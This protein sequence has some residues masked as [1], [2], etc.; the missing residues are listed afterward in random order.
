MMIAPPRHAP[1]RPTTGPPETLRPILEE[2]VLISSKFRLKL[3]LQ[4]VGLLEK[5]CAPTGT[6]GRIGGRPGN[7]LEFALVNGSILA[8]T[9]F[10]VPDCLTSAGLLVRRPIGQLT[11]FALNRGRKAIRS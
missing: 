3:P 7:E 6:F 11:L 10:V 9:I 5:A 4:I 8:G 1:V 2:P